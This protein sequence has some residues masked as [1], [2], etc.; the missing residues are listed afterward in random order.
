LP[1]F[2]INLR[3][4]SS[5]SSPG[6]DEG[7]ES[8]D[9]EDPPMQLAEWIKRLQLDPATPRFCGKSAGH[10]VV[11]DAVG[12][13]HSFVGQPKVGEPTSQLT[14]NGRLIS[15]RAEFWRVQ[16]VPRL[17]V[18]I[19]HG[20]TCMQWEREALDAPGISYGNQ[21]F[22]FPDDD[23][24]P[25]LIDQYY[26]EIDILFPLL[27]RPTFEKSVRERV[28]LRNEGFASVLLLVCA[29]A[30]LFVDHPRVLIDGKPRSAG[31]KYFNQVQMMR[32]SLLAPPSLYDLQVC[33]VSSPSRAPD[34]NPDSIH[35]LRLPSY[36]L[37]QHLNHPGL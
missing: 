26:E 22:D 11:M 1:P 37:H 27:H 3:N 20:L 19:E 16:P 17:E 18:S 33:C 28:H 31:W 10:R 2:T 21:K 36:T 14:L 30:S 32:K 15:C 6:D 7:F 23:L 13:K 8:S 12:L 35:S 24:L 5:A 34:R 9:D 29:I 25:K 4:Y